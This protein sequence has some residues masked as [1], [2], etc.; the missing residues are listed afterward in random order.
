[1]IMGKIEDSLL[2][3]ISGRTGRIVVVNLFGTEITRSRPRKSRLP[4]SAKQKLVQ[5]RMRL[6][7]NFMA[8]YKGYA[9]LFYGT[10]MGTKSCYNQAMA[11]LLLN[12]VIDFDA[13]T[14][15]PNYPE[16]GFSKG[17]LLA[18]VLTGLT[19]V[20]GSKLTLTWQD[21]S[22]GVPERATDLAQILIAIE[23]RTGT[24][25]LENACLRS[26][27]SF[28]VTLPLD[29]IGK[30]VHVWLAFRNEEKTLVS[31]SSYLGQLLLV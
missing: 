6:A 27:E 23:D 11:N 17:N 29:L 14:I 20:A 21:N 8:S 13:K 10:R 24:L 31:N 19:A 15:V 2:A 4:P 7:A 16:M 28:S 5:T 3:G 1:M 18:P 9:S 22:G 25:F 26:E 12:F 30:K